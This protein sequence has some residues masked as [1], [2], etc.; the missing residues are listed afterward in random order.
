M[1]LEWGGLVEGTVG[2][3]VDFCGGGLG[4]AAG[5]AGGCFEGECYCCC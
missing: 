4:Y 2:F 5:A 1:F 3:E